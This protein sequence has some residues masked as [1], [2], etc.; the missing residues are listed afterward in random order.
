[1]FFSLFYDSI[2]FMIIGFC[3]NVKHNLPS[4]DP[5][6]QADIE[7]DAP[8][9]ITAITKALGSGGHE[10]IPIEADELAY[11]KLYKLK[12]KIDIIFNI[13]EGYYGD[14]REAQIPIICDI[15]QIPYT[16]SSALT[17]AV[18]LDKALTKKIFIHH[19]IA[20]PDFQLFISPKDKLNP[21]LK[22]P[23]FLK[24]NAEGSSKGVMN[25]NLVKNKSVFYKRL[26][27]LFEHFRVPV[28]V[29]KFLPGREFTVA[30]L[31]NP[32]QALPIIEQRL[33]RLP[34]EYG[35][36][37][38]YEVKWL[39]ED[40]L[41]DITF[42]YDCPAKIEA[43]LKQQINDLS[44]FAYNA[45]NCRDC[46]RVDIRLDNNG[47]PNVL[48]INTLP[49]LMPAEMG[50]SYF[51]IAVRAAGMSY[52]EMVLAILEAACKRYGLT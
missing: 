27:W 9:V 24:P 52:N 42:A 37:S 28:L 7:F 5:K 50:V 51:P 21:K 4:T 1:M 36:F 20:T 2:F 8:E 32:P 38:S 34:K 23:L 45:L 29:E 35:P 41:D 33:D 17:H 25:D 43:K 11:S 31:G 48:E 10:V 3:Y 15:L 16:H 49:G 12:N 14:A 44:I 19:R 13:A 46:A 18:K 26:K 39:W 40:T 30:I 22:F 47:E 6:A